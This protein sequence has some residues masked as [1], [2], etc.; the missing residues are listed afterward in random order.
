LL[1][2]RT[3]WVFGTGDDFLT[4][5]LRGLRG[6]Q[7]IRGIADQ[8]GSPT[9]VTALAERLLAVASSGVRGLVHLAG[10]EPITWYEVLVRAKELGDFPGT[11]LAQKAD[12]LG[13]PAA[14]PPFSA[15][16]SVVLTGTDVPPMPSLDDS[17]KKVLA[18][19]D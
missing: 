4:N 6:G 5:A 10:P 3:A 11:V 13:R 15:L 18:D 14:R 7:E 12:E 8:V 2:V 17:I 16:T 19:V 9:E 1:I